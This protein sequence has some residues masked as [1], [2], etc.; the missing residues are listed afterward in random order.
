[1]RCG[2]AYLRNVFNAERGATARAQVVEQHVLP[3]RSVRDQPQIGQRLFG[4]TDFALDSGEQV[5][6]VNV[7]QE[8]TGDKTLLMNEG[9]SFEAS[10]RVHGTY[11]DMRRS[12]RDWECCVDWKGI[13]I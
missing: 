12:I 13:Y 5:A 9:H 4:R 1:M 8:K 10:E 11:P 6:C 3:V 7:K 2:V